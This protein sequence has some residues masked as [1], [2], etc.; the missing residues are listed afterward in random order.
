MISEAASI[1]YCRRQFVF[2]LLAQNSTAR[3]I[4]TL[5]FSRSTA[6]QTKVGA[7]SGSGKAVSINSFPAIFVYRFAVPNF[8]ER[9]THPASIHVSVM[10]LMVK[11]SGPDPENSSA[12]YFIR[13]LY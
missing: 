8:P 1:S 6:F 13:G 9:R 7:S 5:S 2:P 12:Q 11:V 4:T 10:I 3:S